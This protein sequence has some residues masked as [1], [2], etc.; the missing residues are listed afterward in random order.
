M[1]ILEDYIAKLPDGFA[2]YPDAQCKA[3][4]LNVFTRDY[5]ELLLEKLPSD[6]LRNLIADPP[7][8]SVWISEVEVQSIFH[9]L[10][11]VEFPVESDYVEYAR[12]MNRELL[13]SGLYRALF[14]VLSHSRVVRMTGTAWAR[15]HIGSTLLVETEEKKSHIFHMEFPPYLLGPINLRAIVTAGEYALELGGAE[16]VYSKIL[17]TSPTSMRVRIGWDFEPGAD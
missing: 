2:S 8:D 7:P 17:E 4:V 6:E 11:E 14:R 10:R 16:R 15:F 9:V 1:R 12:K 13:S 5:R 3:S